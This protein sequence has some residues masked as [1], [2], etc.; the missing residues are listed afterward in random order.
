MLCQTTGALSYGGIPEYEGQFVLAVDYLVIF[1]SAILCK[2]LSVVKRSHVAEDIYH[3]YS[4]SESALF[5]THKLASAEAEKLS[6]TA[7]HV[8]WW[9]SERKGQWISHDDNSGE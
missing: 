7:R 1:R 9:P 8:T 3:C 4:G 6:Q 2:E 5:R